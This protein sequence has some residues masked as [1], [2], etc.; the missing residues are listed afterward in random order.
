MNMDA[1]TY[2]H[3]GGQMQIPRPEYPR[4]QRER[5]E[6]LNLNGLWQFEFDPGLSG[7]ARGL[8]GTDRLSGEILVPFCPESTL[9]GIGDVDFHAGVWYRRTFA[10]PSGWQGMRVLLHVGA[11]DHDAMVWVNG[12][13]A[14]THQ[15]GYT[16]FEMDITALLQRGDNALV[17]HAQD[18]TRAA[19]VLSGKQCPDYYSRR[20][21][22]TRTTGIW[23]TVWLEPV[24]QTY[25]EGL[26]LTPMVEGAQ[27]LVEATLGGIPTR[28]TLT[29]TA[30]L[31]GEIVGASAV[32]FQGHQAILS[33][34]VAEVQTWEPG[35]PVL[36]DLAL[37]VRPEAGAP[38][39]VG[40]Y[41]GMRS[42]ALSDRAILLNGRPVFQRLVLD[43]GYYPDGIYT[44]PNDEALRNDIVISQGLGFN[45]ARLHQKL[46]EP[47]FLYWADRM[48][49]LVWDE[50]PNWGLD[51]SDP[52]AL[53][54]FLP[55]WLEAMHRDYSHPSVVGWC[56]FN[57]TQVDQDP[58]V[59]RGVYRATKASD[60][61]RP[62]IDTS[63]YQHVETDIYDVHNYDQNPA[64]FA[65]AFA[66]LTEGGEPFRN[67]P[68][69]DA[70]YAGQPYFV[71]EYG[72]IWW[73][74]GQADEVGWGY[75]GV[76]GRPQSEE[77]F[78]ARYRALTD[79]LLDH[80]RMC[81]LC[82][83]QLYDIE[84]EVNGLYTYDRKPKFR[85]E[86]FRQINERR[87]AIED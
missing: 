18:D 66:A 38:D 42:V 62:V 86:L 68:E 13:W 53:E 34:P 55:Q 10:V 47:R 3:Q 8:P 39:R 67:R 84:Q 63:G 80:P 2:G 65:G 73:N 75:G 49:Y 22:Y 50:F 72:G 17:I 36:Y 87:A 61:T 52:R 5:A 1:S 15:G 14:G 79:A 28:G 24:P 6:W 83:T 60:R 12:E 40:S 32:S 41:F 57:E 48:G 45:G 33:L 58:G 56:P 51:V 71:S 69:H 43:Q 30:R 9:S 7:V 46:F 78:V 59:I 19:W 16:P 77:E 81:A 64:T 11:C 76:S 4:P 26:R 85:P 74:P 44:A 82:Y 23:Q 37:E 21:H 20:C 35:R 29:A 54:V 70:P 25:I 27:L 31:D